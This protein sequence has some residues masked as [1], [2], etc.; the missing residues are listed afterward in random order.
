MLRSAAPAPI[1]KPGN[2]VYTGYG[3]V[4]DIFYY[5]GVMN[6]GK[7]TRKPVSN[8]H[9]FKVSHHTDVITTLLLM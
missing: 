1:K 6:D 8:L 7:C 3:D 5:Y 9:Y 2:N 4:E